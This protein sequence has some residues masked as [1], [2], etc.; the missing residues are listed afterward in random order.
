MDNDAP[1]AEARAMT[2]SL[3]FHPFSSYCQK[4]LIALYERDVPFEA[5]TVDLGDDEERA[6]LARLWP[7]AKFPV[8]RD[9]ARG[10]TVP[11]SSLIVSYLDRGH[12]G[13][14]PMVPEDPDSALKV[15]ILDRFFDSY[16][17]TPMQKAVADNFRPAEARDAFGVEEA[18][19]HL[20]KAYAI[21]EAELGDGRTWAA[22]DEF[23]L[24]DCAAA[25]SLFYAN[26][27]APFA[28]HKRLEAYYQRLLERPSF[29]R[30]VDEA[31][32]FRHYF[33]LP[34]PESYG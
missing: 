1:A 22:G 12:P 21:L 9:E 28:G 2:L 33:P 25:P 11:E 4:V 26:T 10:V 5:V 3:Y 19:G 7:V 16:V 17:M 20:A 32:P 27:I 18:K 30:A 8:L 31:R 24:A 23:S 29:A 6:A 34:W 15:H 14:R 13:P